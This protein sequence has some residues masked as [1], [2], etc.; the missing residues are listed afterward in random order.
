MKKADRGA[1]LF[2]IRYAR[3]AYT[4]SQVKTDAVAPRSV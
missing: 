2:R 1:R 3:F 4:G